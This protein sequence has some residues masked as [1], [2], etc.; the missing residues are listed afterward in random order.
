[1]KTKNNKTKKNMGNKVSNKTIG[2]LMHECE[3]RVAEIF[4]EEEQYNTKMTVMI[5]RML[6]MKKI[7]K[8]SDKAEKVFMEN[9]KIQ[10][11]VASHIATGMCKLQEERILKHDDAYNI[12]HVTFEFGS[13]DEWN[14]NL[15][16]DIFYLKN[17]RLAK[18]LAEDD[19]V[20]VEADKDGFVVADMY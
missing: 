20:F 12:Y 13:K 1:M 8:T 14:E 16:E 18:M 10:E 2:D 15:C 11:N 7:E 6:A 3:V 17:P 9:P 5:R 19:L 4:G